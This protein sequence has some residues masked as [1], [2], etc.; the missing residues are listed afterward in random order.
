M[1]RLPTH[2]MHDWYAYLRVDVRDLYSSKHTPYL[3]GIGI[4]MNSD[5]DLKHV[6][7]LAQCLLLD[8]SLQG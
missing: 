2:D 6:L 4:C 7:P 1:C 8:C 5:K 3:G